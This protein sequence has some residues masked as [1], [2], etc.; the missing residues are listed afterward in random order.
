MGATPVALAPVGV[1]PPGPA[2]TPGISAKRR[3]GM[4]WFFFP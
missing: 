4:G 1:N 3:F 2:P